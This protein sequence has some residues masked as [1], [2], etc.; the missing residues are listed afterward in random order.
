MQLPLQN[1]TT[2]VSNAAAAVQGSAY[3]LVD[4][5]VGSTLRA[6]LE[7]NASIALWMQWLVLL[8]LRTTRAAT[9]YGA[10]LDSW[11]GDFGLV[12]LPAIPAAGQVTFSR[13]TALAAALVPVGTTVRTGDGTQ[14]FSVSADAANPAFNPGQNGYVLAAGTGAVTVP[15][16]AASAG[17]AGNVQPGA[18]S[19][20]GAALPGIDAVQNNSGTVSGADAETDPALRARFALFFASRSRATPVAIANAIAGVRQ[21]LTYA[22]A[23]NTS[24]DGTFRPGCFVVT[25]DDGS[26]APPASLIASVVAAVDAVRPLGSI[27]AVR[28]PTLVQANVSLTL[29]TN[30]A[31]PHAVLVAQV[32]RA[33]TAA[34]AA[35]PIGSGFAWSRLAQIAFNANPDVYNVVAITLNGG[36]A[37]LLSGPGGIIRPGAIVV[38]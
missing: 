29:L 10:D 18:I 37:D 25:L 9:S 31:A 24:P 36:T 20:I 38:S 7:A 26:G 12:R 35:M 4:L 22:L 34:I 8:V 23:E 15:I 5:T 2:L 13:F 30:P 17:A 32:A 6:I 3:Q 27:F 19:L 14:S 21:N 28:A 11:V 16:V 1:F 33:I